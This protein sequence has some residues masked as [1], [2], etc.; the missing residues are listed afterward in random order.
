MSTKASSRVLRTLAITAVVMLQVGFATMADAAEQTRTLTRNFPVAGTN[1]VRLSNLIGRAHVVAG[2]GDQ[3]AVTAVI[4]VDTSDA[5]EG[6][7]ILDGMKWVEAR[8]YKHR[9]EMALSYPLDDYRTFRRP[10][11]AMHW[12]ETTAHYMGRR[13]RVAGGRGLLLYADLEIRVPDGASLGLRNV[14]GKIDSD[15]VT[16]DLDLDTASGDVAVVGVTGNLK[17]DTGSGDVT[18]GTVRGP[19][20]VDTGSGDV[21]V[22]EVDGEKAYF[23]TGSGNV[24]LHR[25]RL[26]KVHV[27]TGS[28]DVELNDVDA[29]HIDVD[30]GSGDVVMSGPMERAREMLFDTGSGDV[31]IRGGAN[32]TFRLVADQGSGDLRSGYSD[33]R[34]ITKGRYVIGYARGDERTQISVDTGSGD[35]TID[36]LG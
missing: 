5:A 23:D 21:V 34:A 6:K 33:A 12:G 32:A 14:V 7:A 18:V 16:A 3:I 9:S 31:R 19:I 30:T 36:P 35:C 27:D 17:I 29:E 20:Y 2:T 1:V 24:A 10:A 25:G 28:G 13:V 11:G 15:A 4:H 26:A 8:D 22:R